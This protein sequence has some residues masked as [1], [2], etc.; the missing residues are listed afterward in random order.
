VLATE[1]R[2]CCASGGENCRLFGAAGYNGHLG[3]LPS[4][5]PIVSLKAITVFRLD[6]FGMLRGYSVTL[7]KKRSG[8]GASRRWIGDLVPSVQRLEHGQ[9]SG[10][11]SNPGWSPFGTS[12]ASHD[13]WNIGEQNGFARFNLSGNV[14]N[15][16]W[17]SPN[18]GN[19]GHVL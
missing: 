19:T 10:T 16:V 18:D 7:G 8:D 14:L 11:Q 15:I 2:S 13:W 9:P 12:D 3:D 1:L 17:G 4:Q 5:W 6:G